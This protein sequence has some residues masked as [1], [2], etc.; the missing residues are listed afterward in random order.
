MEKILSLCENIDARAAI[1]YRNFAQSA[2]EP[3]LSAFWEEVAVEELEHVRGWQYLKNLS[4]KGALSEVFDDYDQVIAGLR[5]IEK[6]VIGY[7]EKSTQP[8]SIK[9]QFL[10]S[11][12][13]E[14]FMLDAAFI[15][16]YVILEAL[17][18]HEGRQI[19]YLA[20]LTKF[21]QKA[22]E[23]IDDPEIDLIID[24]LFRLWKENLLLVNKARTDFLTSLYNRRG[25]IE[26][27]T[28]LMYL[29][30][31]NSRQSGLLMIDID[32]FKLINDRHG[33]QAGDT[34]L[35]A[36]GRE[37]ASTIRQSDIASRYGGEEFVVYLPDTPAE[38]IRDIAEKI[39]SSVEKSVEMPLPITV[40]VGYSA[41]IHGESTAEDLKTLIQEAD[42]NL[43]KAKDAG[44]NC[45]YGS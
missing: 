45:V 8:L 5:A 1:I 43:Y 44:R 25:F 11:V 28:P 9:E 14:M 21:R 16:L 32:R 3:V 37:I 23:L 10:M 40:S 29:V 7:I 12:N 22:V 27:I 31:R 24:N 4:L 6:R 38:R 2:E 30:S 35:A 41:I 15:K 36:L 42:T 17:S 20:H 26:I 34:V 39:R 13:M 19:D 33:H 18:K